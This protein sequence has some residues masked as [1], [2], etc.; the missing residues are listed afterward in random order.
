MHTAGDLYKSGDFLEL[1]PDNRSKQKQ[2]LSSAERQE[3]PWLRSGVTPATMVL[4]TGMNFIQLPKGTTSHPLNC[5]LKTSGMIL[6][7]SLGQYL[8]IL[9][10]LRPS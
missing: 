4:S 7:C 5:I 8:M 9:A 1:L 6:L 10:L 2:E 3:R